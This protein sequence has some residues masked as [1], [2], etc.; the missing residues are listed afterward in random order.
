MRYYSSSALDTTLAAPLSSSATVMTVVATT[1]FPVLTPY[2]LAIEAGNSNK[3]IVEVTG[4]SGTSLTVVRGVDGTGGV[5]HT[6]GSTVSH[7]HSARDFRE[8]QDHM[9]ATAAHGASGAVVGTTNTQTLSNKTLAS[10]TITG[11]PSGIT[12]A[13]VGLGN[14]DNTSDVSKPVSTAQAAAIST[15]QSTATTAATAAAKTYTDTKVSQEAADR[16]AAVTEVRDRIRMGTVSIPSGTGAVTVTVP[17]G[18]TLPSTAY[19]VFV[20]PNSL[21]LDNCSSAAYTT[22]NFE[23]SA[24]RS[25]PGTYSARW[26]LVRT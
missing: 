24:L 23:V 9:N 16:D 4:V 3:E 18:I 13:H 14:V 17:I 19:M 22:T 10:P 12:K 11:T 7:V 21:L 2:T 6:L 25:G 15:A 1:G 26:I 5:A 20:T 8:P